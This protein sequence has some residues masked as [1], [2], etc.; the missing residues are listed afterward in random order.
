MKRI[1]LL[2]LCLA[3]LLMPAPVISQQIPTTLRHPSPAIDALWICILP[4]RG[5]LRSYFD[6]Q[7]DGRFIF[8]EGDSITEK[9]PHS[10]I[11]SKKLVQRAFQIVSKPSVLNAVDT[12]PG[13]TIFSDSDWVSIGLM[14]GGTVKKRGGW[15]YRG[16]EMKDFPAEFQQL[17]GE[18]RSI[19]T[20]LPQSTNIK[21]LLSAEVVDE[22][23][24]GLIGRDRFIALDEAA[25]EKFPAL[26]QAVLMSRRM[27]AVDDEAQMSRLAELARRMNPAS[28]YWGWYKIGQSFYE[29][30]AY[31]LQQ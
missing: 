13:E 15:M 29:I 19:A 3:H 1:L 10:G 22:K 8:A 12:D 18:L 31:Y 24:L 26:K 2:V 6:L 17:M 9:A 21:A 14:T 5:Q 27:V 11:V 28:K 7:S 20:K 25:L 23:R 30:G 16:E 4:T